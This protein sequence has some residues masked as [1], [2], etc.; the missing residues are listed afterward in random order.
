MSTGYLARTASMG[1]P[2]IEKL[3]WLAP[4]RPGDTLT[5]TFTATDKRVSRSRPEMGILSVTV[6]LDNQHGV[7]VL[8]M[9][10]TLLCATRARAA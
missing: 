3:A 7:A 5:G 10:A 8:E 2:G 9:Q 4:V 6:R 1:S